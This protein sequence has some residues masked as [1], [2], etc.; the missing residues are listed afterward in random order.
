LKYN[1]FLLALPVIMICAGFWEGCSTVKPDST[2]E[3]ISSDR[4]VNKLEANRRKIRNFEGTGSISVK[5]PSFDN[6]ASFRIVIQKPDSI[7]LTIYGPF[8]IELAQILV[9]K[10]NF[11]FYEA[12]KNTAFTGPVN[13]DLLRNVFKVNLS[14]NDVID[15]FTGGVNMSGRLYKEPTSFD[16]VQDK[17][18]LS[19]VDSLKNDVARYTAD[20]R[21]LNIVEFKSADLQGKEKMLSNYSDFQIFETVSLPKKIEIKQEKEGQY[22]T[23]EYN[24]ISV[25]KNTTTIDFSLPDDADVVKW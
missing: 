10:T 8:S 25:N 6:S 15:A 14:F 4:L 11:I 21:D 18:L 22:I 13:D 20:V 9:T 16:V 12:L 17:Y 3:Y 24:N 5:T 2:I 23:I 19:Y 7:F 1:K